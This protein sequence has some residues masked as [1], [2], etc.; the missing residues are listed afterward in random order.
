MEFT[1]KE[2]KEDTKQKDTNKS[3]NII[4]YKEK[5]SKKMVLISVIAACALVVL[6][7][8]STGFALFNINSNKIIKG[9]LIRGTKIGGLTQEEAETKLK[10]KIE[11][12]ID[13]DIVFKA[14]D[15]EYSIKLS[16]IEINYNV[17][18]AVEDAYKIGRD[19]NI[20]SNN[21]S[22]VKTRL[23]NKEINMEYN[24]N[25][26][27]L[28]NI[29]ADVSAKIPDAVV[30]PS[31][32]IEDDKLIIT[33]GKKGNSIDKEDVKNKLINIIQNDDIEKEIIMN[34]VESEPQE[35]DIEKYM[36]KYLKNLKMHITQKIHFKYFHMKMELILT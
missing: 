28:N 17:T 20:F 31:Y 10:E 1:N 22:I 2:K 12:K 32:Y 9:V 25:E 19:G 4:C 18:K 14:N 21:F 3:Q 13:E 23:K 16:Q 35:I 30:E 7:Y 24:Y 34:I 27:L 5:N 6:L 36:K 26:E 29:I 8:A 33:K 11:Q 15:F